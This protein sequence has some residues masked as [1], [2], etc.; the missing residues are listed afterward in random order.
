MARGRTHGLDLL[1]ELL[2]EN[3]GVEEGASG[4][5]SEIQTKWVRRTDVLLGDVGVE[6][7]HRCLVVLVLER[8]ADDLEHGRDAG[9]ARDH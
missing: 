5:R 3:C 6:E 2:A 1:I 9:S 8:G 4:S 7:R